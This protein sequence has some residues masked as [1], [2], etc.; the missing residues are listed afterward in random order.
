[1]IL[2]TNAVS[3]LADGD[4]KLLAVVSRVSRFSLPVIVLGEYR[5]GI[6]RSRHRQRYVDWLCK[7][8]MA[9]TVLSIDEETTEH[10]AALREALRESGHP[11]PSN[12]AWIAALAFQ[13]RLPVVTRDA[14]FDWVQGLE[15]KTW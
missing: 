1:V 15:R 13:H 7:L 11:I 4:T 10:Y 8:T 14:H 5:F 6:A 3:A 9:S 2:D 12:D